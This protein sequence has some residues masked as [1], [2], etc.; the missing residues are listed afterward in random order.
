MRSAASSLMRWHR[1]SVARLGPPRCHGNAVGSSR[2]VSSSS[3]SASS[4]PPL[5]PSVRRLPREDVSDGPTYVIDIGAARV[6][7]LRFLAF[8]GCGT[9]FTVLYKE[10]DAVDKDAGATSS[11]GLG[12]AAAVAAGDGTEGGFD[13]GELESSPAK[14][15]KSKAKGKG[16]TGKKGVGGSSQRWSVRLVGPDG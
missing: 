3:L 2:L 5:P 10:M 12:T 16:D 11:G 8:H 1:P 6:A 15:G 13:A 7:H 9:R 14:K 4:A